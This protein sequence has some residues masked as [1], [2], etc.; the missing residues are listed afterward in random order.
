MAI[1]TSI[2][3]IGRALK[4]TGRKTLKKSSI[5]IDS[6]RINLII[7]S[8]KNKIN[9]IYKE[10]GKRYYKKYK[11]DLSK[12]SPF[13]KLFLDIDALKKEIKELE[14]ELLSVNNEKQCP[15][16]GKFID[17][18]SLFCNKCGKNL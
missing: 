12:D 4:D 7:S 9:D 18:K 17:K 13:K 8:K 14:Q 6:S 3:D 10:I 16:C 2:N 11:K 15:H 5:F 1:K